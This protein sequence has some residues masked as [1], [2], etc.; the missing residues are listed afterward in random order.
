MNMTRTIGRM[1]VTLATAGLMAAAMAETTVAY[2]TN[3]NTNEG[4]TLINGGAKKAGEKEGIKFI[5]LAAEQG[6]LSKQLAIVEDMITRKVDAIAIAPVDSAG[7]APAINKALAAGIKVVAVDTGISG[8]DITSYV[9]TD[10]IKAAMVQGEWVASQ[11]KDGDTVIYVTGDQGQST[12]QERRKG[13]LDG[14]NA[15]RKNVKVVEV[16]TRWDQTQAQNGVETALRA[17]PGAKVIA[18]AWDGGALG[19]KAA[20]LSSGKRKGSIKIAGFDGSP[21]GLDMMKQGW[22]QANAAQ[23]L[24]RIGQIGVETAIAAA[25]GKKVD[26]RIDTG[27]FLVLPSNVDQFA[28]D[29]GVAQFMRAK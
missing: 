6:E 24:A 8:A 25:Q 4:W 12:G 23:M 1:A 21:G 22:Q 15:K 7:I 20:M 13:F 17:N 10:N 18:C 11:V 29:S 27:S 19:A 16:P 14:L 28:K 26:A 9:A 2:I 5:Q 3:G